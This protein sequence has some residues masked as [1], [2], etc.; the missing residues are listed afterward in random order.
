MP[1][2]L[3]SPKPVSSDSFHNTNVSKCCS[4]YCLYSKQVSLGGLRK[5]FLFIYSIFENEKLIWN[6]STSYGNNVWICKEFFQAVFKKVVQ[7]FFLILLSTYM[8]TLSKRTFF[9]IFLIRSTT[10]CKTTVVV[11]Q[12]V[13]CSILKFSHTGKKKSK[14]CFHHSLERT[15]LLKYFKENFR[16]Y[17]F[18]SNR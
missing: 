10:V 7:I 5:K 2:F 18:S 15:L 12:N 9:K 8:N 1:F 14:L 13:F 3:C 17:S 11:F 6:Q 16:T 4:L